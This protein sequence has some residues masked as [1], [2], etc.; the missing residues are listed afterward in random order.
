MFICSFV[1]SRENF[2]NLNQAKLNSHRLG[3]EFDQLAARLSLTRRLDDVFPRKRLKANKWSS[4]Y[5]S[6]STSHLVE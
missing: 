3:I 4:H 1:G 5:A 2:L 6:S